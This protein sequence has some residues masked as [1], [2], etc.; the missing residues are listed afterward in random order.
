[1]LGLLQKL[2]GLGISGGQRKDVI[3]IFPPICK[4]ILLSPFN[5]GESCGSGEL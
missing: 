2:R 4:I 5:K 1:M 3:L